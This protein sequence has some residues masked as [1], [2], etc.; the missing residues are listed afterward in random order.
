MGLFDLFQRAKLNPK[1]EALADTED[2]LRMIM[3][4]LLEEEGKLR[5][6]HK[7]MGRANGHNDKG[8]RQ[9][10]MGAAIL[11]LHH[12]VVRLGELHWEE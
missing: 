11:E 7:K 10:L 12:V 5:A 3:E 4:R 6:I 2:D 9:Y 8:V 1:Q